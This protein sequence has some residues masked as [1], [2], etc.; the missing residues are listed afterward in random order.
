M[1]KKNGLWLGLLVFGSVLASADSGPD[2]SGI[3]KSITITNIS[4]LSGNLIG[5]YI[6]EELPLHGHYETRNTAV[7]Y[8]ILGEAEALTIDLMDPICNTFNAAGDDCDVDPWSGTGDYYVAILNMVKKFNNSPKIKDAYV[9]MD[10]DNVP[11]KVSF[12]NEYTT[13]DFREFKLG[14]E[15]YH[16]KIA[17]IYEDDIVYEYERDPLYVDDYILENDL[18]IDVVYDGNVSLLNRNI[19]PALLRHFTSLELRLLRNMIFAKYNYR[20]TSKD[21]RDYF[22]RFSWY[23]GAKRYAQNS[24]SAVDW[25]NIRVIQDLE[26]EAARESNAGHFG[27]NLAFTG[28]LCRFQYLGMDRTIVKKIKFDG[29][30]IIRN[31]RNGTE[32]ARVKTT[33]SQF[34]FEFGEIPPESLSRWVKENYYADKLQCSD[35]ELKTFLLGFYFKGTYIDLYGV[36]QPAYETV[37]ESG[38][39]YYDCYFYMYADR[40]AV[41]Q[42]AVEGDAGYTNGLASMYPRAAVRTVYSVSLKKGWNKLKYFIIYNG[43]YIIAKTQTSS[44]SGF[45]GNER[46]W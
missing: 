16:M 14:D 35:R 38:K 27:G 21:L 20:F 37:E 31:S 44:E 12:L 1:V 46:S 45:Y 11:L 40:D 25:Q 26:K 32:I 24:M 8:Y 18:L 43:K 13:V 34:Q 10:R 5:I 9:L 42:G 39:G 4:E 28:Q 33:D 15:F 41:I 7:Q 36:E 29:E 3:P 17:S 2:K 22:S 23:T 30:M 19:E 6:F